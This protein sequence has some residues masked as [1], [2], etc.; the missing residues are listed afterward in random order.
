[1]KWIFITFFVASIL[2]FVEEYF[3][4]GGFMHF[5]GRLNP[6]FAPHL[7]VSSALS[8]NGLQLLL[9]VIVIWVGASNLEFSM[10]LAALLF[11]NGMMH[12]VGCL[13]IRGYAPGVVTGT[14]L[15]LPLSAYAYYTAIHSHQLNLR[16]AVASVALG[17]VYQA[18]PIVWFVLA[19][20]HR[21][22]SMQ[23]RRMSG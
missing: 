1:M 7:T 21:R 5:V 16:G 11:L 18:V 8:I 10:S 4:P 22:S 2:H 19:S 6:G 3:Y 17:L 9:C 13:R 15:Y 20:M 14:M 23:D 12:I